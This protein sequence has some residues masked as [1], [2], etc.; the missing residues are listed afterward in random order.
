MDKR[1]IKHMVD[2]FLS[3]SLPEDFNPDAGISFE[4]RVRATDE[5]MPDRMPTGTNLFDAGQAMAMVEHMLAGLPDPLPDW[6]QRVLEER[7]ELASRLAKLNA[8]LAKRDYVSQSALNA[9]Q[10]QQAAMGMY[11]S[12]LDDRIAEF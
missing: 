3:W 10:K 2:R 4:R 8:Y 11:L 9:L 6:Q 1:Q 12:A 7:D 5:T